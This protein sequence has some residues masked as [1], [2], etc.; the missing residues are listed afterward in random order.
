MQPLMCQIQTQDFEYTATVIDLSFGGARLQLPPDIANLGTGRIWHLAIDD[1]GGFDVVFRWRTA[2]RAGVSF[3]SPDSAHDRI[4]AFF[5]ANGIA[6]D[7]R[8]R[9][10]RVLQ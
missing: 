10:G 2:D 3:R 6:H 5:D 7:A 9:P 8:R 4:A 1:L